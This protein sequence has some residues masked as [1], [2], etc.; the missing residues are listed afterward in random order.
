VCAACVAATLTGDDPVMHVDTYDEGPPLSCDNCGTSIESSYGDLGPRD[1]FDDTPWV[2]ASA[3][4]Y[5]PSTEKSFY[6]SSMELLARS[7][8]DSDES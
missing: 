3:V 5:P 8:Q 1:L 6:E 7:I 4:D 2:P